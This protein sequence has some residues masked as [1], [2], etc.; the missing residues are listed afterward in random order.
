MQ[1]LSCVMSLVLD[2]ILRVAIFKILMVFI[3][4][5][6]SIRDN[7]VLCSFCTF[8]A[9]IRVHLDDKVRTKTQIVPST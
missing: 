4:F 9:N 6:S 7:T 8:L 3:V 2:I 1:R 5:V